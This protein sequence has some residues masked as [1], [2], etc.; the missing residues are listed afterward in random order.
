MNLIKKIF[1]ILFLTFTAC[2]CNLRAFADVKINNVNFDNS[3][4]FMFLSTSQQNTTASETEQTATTEITS[5]TLKNPDRIFFDITNAI[6][7]R[8]NETW[9]F[10]NSD[11]SQIKV[12][13]FSTN[14]NVVRVVFYH[15][16]NFNPKKISVLN[17]KGN[18]L[19][20]YGDIK[21]QQKDFYTSYR[22][23]HTV[24]SD[25]IEKTVYIPASEVG[26]VAVNPELA[27]INAQNIQKAFSSAINT[28]T[29]E[30]KN[31]SAP[32]ISNGQPNSFDWSKV[33]KL[34]TTFFLSRVD[35]K[36]GN[37]LILGSGRVQIEKPIFLSNPTRVVF[38]MPNTVV[39][40]K[41]KNVEI[42]LTE[43][44]TLKIG[45]FEPT[46]VRLVITTNTPDKYRPIFSSDGQGLLLGHDNKMSGIKL[47]DKGAQTLKT[48]VAQNDALTNTF[49]LQ[50]AEPVVYSAKETGNKFELMVYNATGFNDEIFQ[51]AING[52]KLSDVQGSKM[53]I[54]GVKYVFNLKQN[55]TA[56]I[57]AREDGKQLKIVIKNN[58]SSISNKNQPI[59]K[60]DDKNGYK[61]CGLIIIDPGHGGL[62]TGAIREN[63][64]EKDINLEVS[65]MVHSILTKKGYKADLTRWDDKTLSLQDRVDISD[66]RL[67]SVFVSIHVNSSVNEEP[68][69]IETHWWTDEGH[70]LAKVV[71][72][73]FA[74]AVK[75]VD[76][77]LVKSKFYVINHT[78]AKS[79]LVEIGFLSNDN[80]RAELLTKERKQ[81]TAE[82]IAEG[83]MKF[84]KKEGIK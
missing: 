17:I 25:F 57:Q 11:I 13:Q 72:S 65:K 70:E 76:R 80:E 33:F 6:L 3:A 44:E 56:D 48:T 68:N 28:Q 16:A 77:G 54:G 64:N 66:N 55:A 82:G 41:F 10:R 26:K 4:G 62:D 31:T 37:I 47:Y 20:K 39:A 14:P 51:N 78:K 21:L 69:G 60:N 38:D 83:I 34:R 29:N 18:Y 22:S 52:S 1:L 42:Q 63:I 2:F 61:G 12:S 74:N 9:Y 50:Y 7:T 67:A 30:Q 36:R 46:K 15:N 40:Q 19:F 27:T 73:S 24:A 43:T 23:E 79:V 49:K 75:A 58:T 81:K 8:P 71:H 45:Q 84:M 5:T 53:N 35:I 59:I 32:L